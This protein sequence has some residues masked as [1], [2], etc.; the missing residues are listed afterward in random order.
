M[1]DTVVKNVLSP[2][3]GNKNLGNPKG[4]KFYLQSTKDI[5]KEADKLDISV[6]NSKEILDHFSV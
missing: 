1:S 3:E 6:S 5:D 2:F 4:I